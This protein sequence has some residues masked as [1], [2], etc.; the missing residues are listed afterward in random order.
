MSAYTKSVPIE[1]KKNVETTLRRVLDLVIQQNKPCNTLVSYEVKN[2]GNVDAE[3]SLVFDDAKCSRNREKRRR[4][5][6]S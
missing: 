3:V 6:G 2:L 5:K 4:G 1:E